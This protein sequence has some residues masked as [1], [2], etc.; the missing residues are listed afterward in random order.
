MQGKDSELIHTLNSALEMGRTSTAHKAIEENRKRT[1]RQA[2]LPE[3]R[4]P[5]EALGAVQQGAGV[6]QAVNSRVPAAPSY[7]GWWQVSRPV[8]YRPYSGPHSAQDPGSTQHPQGLCLSTSPS[9][10]FQE[11]PRSS[12]QGREGETRPGSATHSPGDLDEV[13]ALLGPTSY[14]ASGGCPRQTGRALSEHPGAG[15]LYDP[16]SHL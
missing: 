4:G 12:S 13:T 15:R 5:K 6:A 3:L 9:A 16:A 10:D 8:S 14:C 2:Q 11:E 7:E 1:W